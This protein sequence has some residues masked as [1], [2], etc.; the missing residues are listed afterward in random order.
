MLMMRTADNLRHT[1]NLINVFPEA[2]TAAREAID[3]IMKPPVVE[4]MEEE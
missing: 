2:A 3:L 4:E 1:A